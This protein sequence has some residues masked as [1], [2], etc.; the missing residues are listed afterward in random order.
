MQGFDFSTMSNQS[1]YSSSKDFCPCVQHFKDDPT[2]GE[3]H[4]LFLPVF[5]L[6]AFTRLIYHDGVALGLINTGSCV[7]FPHFVR[8]NIFI[9]GFKESVFPLHCMV[10]YSTHSI[11]T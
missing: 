6:L 5:G 4:Y 10:Q 3:H 8:N 7:Y 9:C 1:E 11:T 2:D